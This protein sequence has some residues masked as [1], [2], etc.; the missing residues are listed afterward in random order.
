MP[1]PSPIGFGRSDEIALSD[2]QAGTHYIAPIEP[3]PQHG[4]GD[5]EVAMTS[6]AG[7]GMT[8][9]ELDAFLLGSSIF[10]KIATTM[11][12]GQPVVSP[13]WYDWLPNDLAF[14]VVSKERTSMVKNLRRDPRCGLVV[15]N[16]VSP[17]RRVSV[18]GHVEFLAQDFDW[19]TPARAMAV[20]YLGP[21][22]ATY[23]EATFAF[24][25]VPFLVR[26]TKMA[27]WNG[28]GFD[29]TFHRDTTWTQA[30][31]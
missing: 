7:R 5:S 31:S 17:Y 18:Q 23:A 30:T 2:A 4:R 20:R 19:I 9:Q 3:R 27:T 13:V 25:R 24:P 12:D 26:V 21:E 29:R 22:G 10:A 14:L 8:E 6:D 28:G 16:P 1:R 15:D 11:P